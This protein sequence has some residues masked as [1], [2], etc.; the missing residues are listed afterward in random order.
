MKHAAVL[1]ALAISANAAAQQEA[2]PT[3][4][5][6]LADGVYHVF[7]GGYSS[8]VV[9]GDNDV[10]ITD[11]ALPP[12]AQAL[13]E[14]ID[15]LTDRPVTK[16]ALSHEH[17]DHVGG[18]DIFEGA[19][20]ICHV[21]CVEVFKLDTLGLAPKKVDTTFTDLLRI[22]LGGQIVELHHW[23]PGDGD[24]ATI[25]YLPEHGIAATADLYE[26]Q[27]LTPAAFIADKNYIGTRLILNR[28]AD[29]NLKHAINSHS[30]GTDPQDIVAARDYYNDLYDAV[31][32][33][34]DAALK[35]GGLFAAFQ[36][37]QSLP[38]TLKLPKYENWQN[39]EEALP[40]H[41]ERVALGIFHGE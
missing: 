7:L 26:P 10:L 38:G 4:V 12:R 17:Y 20:V 28:L 15:K 8:L 27:S 32:A 34:I 37:S 30:P 16:I 9:I 6:E 2:P 33:E 22:D 21:A 3:L 23:G 36:V 14:E 5:N 39:Y 41:V 11:T 13:K 40:A 29:M 35:E 24:A 31:W 18:T 19:E 25:V 1:C